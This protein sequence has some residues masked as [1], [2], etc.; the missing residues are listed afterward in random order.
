MSCCDVGKLIMLSQ[1]N[2]MLQPE[3]NYMKKSDWTILLIDKFIYRRILYRYDFV[4][5]IYQHEMSNSP[6]Q[7]I[8]SYLGLQTIMQ[9]S[10]YIFLSKIIK[11]LNITYF[12][13]DSRSLIYRLHSY[14]REQPIKA[15]FHNLTFL[16]IMNHN[17][18]CLNIIS[19]K[20]FEYDIV[21]LRTIMYNW[22][23]TPQ[24][25]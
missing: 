15:I 20:Y 23:K 11:I 12:F 3:L 8:K 25:C 22:K 2:Q 6:C 24:V 13:V 1:S 18:E 7:Y 10:V 14:V 4:F 21:Y 16:L 9:I 17:Q 5:L 19:T